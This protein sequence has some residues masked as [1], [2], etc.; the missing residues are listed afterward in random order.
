M[1][2]YTVH[3]LTGQTFGENIWSPWA[4]F[5]GMSECNNFYDIK[6]TEGDVTRARAY[7]PRLLCLVRYLSH[8]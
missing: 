3:S 8:H 5:H 2:L 6:K 4:G 1:V 7:K